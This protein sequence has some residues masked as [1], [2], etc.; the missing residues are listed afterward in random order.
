MHPWSG[1]KTG[2]PVRADE[3]EPPITL[4][5]RGCL[6]VARKHAGRAG[7]QRKLAQ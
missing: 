4:T 1:S 3:V 2:P 5:K 7:Q 6:V